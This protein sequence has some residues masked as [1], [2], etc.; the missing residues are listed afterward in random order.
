MA[1]AR[2]LIVRT[3]S[4]GL[5]LALSLARRGVPF[6]L[7]SE[8]EGPGEHSHRFQTVNL[9]LSILPAQR[10]VLP[11]PGARDARPHIDAT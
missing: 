11:A 3:G 5:N 2:V 7:I 4:T 10:P 6:R 1:Y 8:S 9:T